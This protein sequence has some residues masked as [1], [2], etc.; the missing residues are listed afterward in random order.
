M[1]EHTPPAKKIIV[2]LGMHR[3]GT[4][5][6]TRALSTLGVDLGDRLMPPADGNNDK[7]FWEDIDF[8]LMNIELLKTLG[9]DWHTLSPVHPDEWKN[10]ALDTFRQQAMEIVKKKVE[11][12]DY[13]GVKDPRMARTLPF[14][15]S[16]FESIKL[17][18]AYVIACRNPANA[19][20][21]L[22]NRDGF[23]LEK[24]Y[25]LWHEHML[26]S[27]KYSENAQRVFVDYDLLLQSPNEQIERLAK[28][29]GLNFKADKFELKEFNEEFLEKGLRHHKLDLNLLKVDEAAPN[30]VVELSKMITS[31]A[32]DTLTDSV[33][34]R[35]KTDRLLENL[36]NHRPAFNLMRHYDE[37]VTESMKTILQKDLQIRKHEEDFTAID[38][39][40]SDLS[41]QLEVQKVKDTQYKEKIKEYEKLMVSEQDIQKELRIVLDDHALQIYKLQ[42]TQAQ[43]LSGRFLLSS[44][45]RLVAKR[46]I[47][48]IPKSQAR[49]KAKILKM[50]LMNERYYLE[51]Y[52]D[53]KQAGLNP[54]D[55]YLNHGW[56]EGRNPSEAFATQTYIDNYEDVRVSGISPLEHYARYGNKEGRAIFDITGHPYLYNV[57]SGNSNKL[58]S[59]MRVLINDPSL[60]TRF[61]EESKRSGIRQAIALAK[62]KMQREQRTG[63]PFEQSMSNRSWMEYSVFQVVPYNLNPY[64]H[65]MPIITPKN[66][67][68]HLHFFYE[69]MGDICVGYLNNI[70]EKFDLFVS[71]APEKNIDEVSAFFSERLINVNQVVVEHTQNRG[72]DIAPFI[73]QFGQ[74][75]SEYDYIG[76]FHTKKS[77]HRKDLN[78]WFSALMDTL[79]G[80]PKKVAQIFKLLEGDGKLVY[81]S[82]NQVVPGDN[83]WSDNKEIAKAILDRYT[84][85]NIS[86]FPYVEFPQGTMFWAKSESIRDYLTLP[87]KFEDFQKEPILPDATLAHAL[88]RLLLI[89]TTKHPGRNYRLESADLSA[90]PLPYYEEQRDYSDSFVHDT[91][92]ILA[93]YLPQFSPNPENDE[94]HGK[95][96]TEWHKVRAANPLFHGHY[97]QHVPHADIGYYQLDSHEQMAVQAAQMAQAGVHG[98]I[99]YHYW[100]SGKLI[101]EKPAQTLLDHPEIN[102]PFSFCWANENWTRRWDGNEQEIL[103]G[104]IYSKEDASAFIQYLIPFFKDDR[105]IKIDGRPVLFVYRPSSMEFVNEYIDIWA[106]ECL[107]QGVGAPFVV[108]T[109]TRGA[110]APQDYGMDAAVERVLQDWTDGAVPEIKSQKHPY[111]PING[112][113]LDYSSVADHY[114]EK[115]LTNDYPLFRS[116]VPTWDNTARYGTEAFALDGFTTS[117]FQD[118]LEH[119]IDYSEQNLPEDR[120]FVVINAWNEWAE[121]AHLE[122]DTRFGY[123]YLNSVGRA[124]SGYKFSDTEYFEID[125]NT[126]VNIVFSS[127]VTKQLGENRVLRDAF[128]KCVKNSN[129]FSKCKITI[130]DSDLHGYLKSNSVDTELDRQSTTGLTLEFNQVYLFPSHTIEALI[131]MSLRHTGFN[132]CAS[133][134]NDEKVLPNLKANNTEIEFA[135]RSGMVLKPGLRNAGYKVCGT[136]PCFKLAATNATDTAQKFAIS[137]VIRF[138]KQGDKKLLLNCLLSLITQ[139]QCRV[140]PILAIQDMNDEDIEALKFEIALL[141]WLEGCFPEIQT[142]ASTPENPDLR[143]LMMNEGL[144][145]IKTGYAT[146]LDYDD[147][148]FPESFNLLAKRLSSTGK[149]ATFGRVYSTL[150]DSNSSLILSRDRTYTYGYSYE[151]FVNLNHA[152]IHSF[153]IDV[154]KCNI[155]SIEYAPDM[156]Y[157]EDYYLTLQLF[158][159][160]GTDWKSLES[161]FFIGDYIHRVGSENSNTLA[162][163]DQAQR[164]ALLASESYRQSQERINELRARINTLK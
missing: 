70:P 97:Q 19:A 145:S 54:L 148:V 149:N 78:G 103:L 95:G 134:R 106:A 34:V 153:M 144:K 131:K 62:A 135:N 81:S 136:A 128:F 147:V 158:T 29:L 72:R 56:Q 143:S 122:P 91:I 9:H 75:L 99:F 45:A 43:Y 119:L 33:E 137:T 160:E 151:D 59:L 154:S 65:E 152:P 13:F 121:G 100:F 141:P 156:K 79:C 120:R 146:F 25:F 125:E 38:Q 46:A 140:H 164:A 89:F 117:K 1:T 111:W 55:H 57:A 20:R 155:E 2:V 16:I 85:F 88:E 124:L 133:V 94:W 14:W 76:H 60:I 80:D 129:I 37:Q 157:M 35:E 73:V 68:V 67:A 116:L 49:I 132:I 4:S 163:S 86:D 39:K 142:Y 127:A 52:Q 130:A 112:S 47:A 64:L 83:G 159:K 48:H 44:L 82:G 107:A 110:T 6:I 63:A 66:I 93:Y 77:P 74:R 3:C 69:D 105:Y 18:A 21:S 104:Q 138:H 50:G 31:V 32:N 114:I 61:V 84:G 26:L 12:T 40:I 36:F 108:A 41:T 24:G 118:W 7:G 102:M 126:V 27:L 15:L 123:G 30:E 51:T 161:E 53:V 162:V 10:P 101:L 23:A 11:K 5:V 42:E 92:K 71:V 87:L 8:N 90:A 28:G 96:F 113:I 17:D 150:V 139:D 22:A 109:L 98:M 58:V 115:E